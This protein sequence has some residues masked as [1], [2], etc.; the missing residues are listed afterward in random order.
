MKPE[1]TRNEKY[2]QQRLVAIREAA[3]VFA[4]KGFHGASTRDIAERIGIKQASLY[5][6]FDSKLEALEEV[7]PLRN[8][9]LRRTHGRHSSQRPT[10]RGAPPGRDHQPPEQLPGKERSLEGT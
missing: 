7:L 5:Y 3:S 10:L 6:Y 1:P 2:H 4:A 9:G 8:S